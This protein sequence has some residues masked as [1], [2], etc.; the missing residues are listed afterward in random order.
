[1]RSFENVQRMGPNRAGHGGEWGITRARRADFRAPGGGGE[2]HRLTCGGRRREHCPGYSPFTFSQGWGDDGGSDGGG[3]RPTLRSDP[4]GTGDVGIPDPD[5]LRAGTN[6]QQLPGN[7]RQQQQ[8][9]A[10]PRI[11]RGDGDDGRK[12][13]A[14]GESDKE[15]QDGK[16]Q[17][18]EDDVCRGGDG[19]NR[20][21]WSSPG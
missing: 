15:E 4:W 3:G 6:Q 16:E 18:P 20:I 9:C 5:V 11:K 19:G 10:F 21:D 8:L 7:G 12:A 2:N 14:D 13:S 1:M 17:P